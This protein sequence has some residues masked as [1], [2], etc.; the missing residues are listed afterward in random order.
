MEKATLQ[1]HENATNPPFLQKFISFLKH[2]ISILI[3]FWEKKT[4]KKQSH[5][6][7]DKQ[8]ISFFVDVSIK[9]K[10]KKKTLCLFELFETFCYS[11][12]FK[13]L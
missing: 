13:I 6:S 10:N 11:S 12:M 8:N 9:K 1:N 5:E 3:S 7:R 4:Q 2:F